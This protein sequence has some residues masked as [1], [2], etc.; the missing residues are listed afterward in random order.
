VRAV[1]LGLCGGLWLGLSACFDSDEDEPRGG[2]A[3]DSATDST[4]VTPSTT[5][6]GSES[7]S[8]SDSTVASDSHEDSAGN[9]DWTCEDGIRCVQVCIND[10]LVG[11]VP[12]DPDLTCVIACIEMLTV[13]EAYAFLLLSNCVADTCE[14]D[15]QCAPESTVMEPAASEDLP[16]GTCLN[17][18]RLRIGNS[19]LPGCESEHALCE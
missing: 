10:L 12:P 17:C 19:D 8:S 6:S 2:T 14:A 13:Q 5:T 7:T 1:E 15:G 4:T 11:G 16:V 3:A 9:P 18:M